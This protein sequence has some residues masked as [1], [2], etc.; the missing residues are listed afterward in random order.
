[1]M[2]FRFWTH[3]SHALKVNDEEARSVPAHR[4]T[5]TVSVPERISLLTATHEEQLQEG[6]NS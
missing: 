6:I 2:A 5:P 4:K 1:M 3:K